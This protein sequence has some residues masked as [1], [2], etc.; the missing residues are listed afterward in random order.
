MGANLMRSVYTAAAAITSSGLGMHSHFWVAC[1]ATMNSVKPAWSAWRAFS[2]AQS[3]V[4]RLVRSGRMYGMWMMPES[5]VSSLLVGWDVVVAFY[6]LS[7]VAD[8]AY[9]VKK[10][11]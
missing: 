8:W 11:S 3:K 10:M 9:D 6:G 1:S 4:C 7:C 2:R 5:I